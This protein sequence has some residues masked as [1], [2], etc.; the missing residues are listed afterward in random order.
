MLSQLSYAPRRSGKIIAEE[1]RIRLFKVLWVGLPRLERGTSVLSG[2]RSSQLSYRPT[3]AARWSLRQLE[4]EKQ[5]T[6]NTY[7]GHYFSN[8]V[9][10]QNS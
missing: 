3:R 8:A 2:L 7:N 9:H 6:R 1:T 10:S 4:S 5:T